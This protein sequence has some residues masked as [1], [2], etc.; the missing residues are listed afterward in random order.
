M[1]ER[2]APGLQDLG[3]RL[4]VMSG[5]KF[6]RWLVTLALLV[7]QIVEERRRAAEGNSV[8]FPIPRGIE[9]GVGITILELANLDKMIPRSAW[10]SV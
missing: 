1:L 9:V 10:I 6:R 7:G 8:L 4:Q 3:I 2:A 5:V